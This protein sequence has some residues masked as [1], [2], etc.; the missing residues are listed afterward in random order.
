MASEI[1]AE[2]WTP[3]VIRELL[4]GGHTFNDILRGVPLMSRSLLSKRLRELE[5]AGLIEK[6]RPG[7]RGTPEYHLTQAGRELEPVMLQLTEWGLRWARSEMQKDQLDPRPLM[8]DIHR[9]INNDRLPPHRVVVNFVFSDAPRAA[10]RRTWLVL[11]GPDVDVCFKDPGYPVD[12]VV[13][14]TVRTL[15]AVWLGDLPWDRAVRAE[16]MTIDGRRE[17]K[18]AFPTWLALSGVAGAQFR[19]P[20]TVS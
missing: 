19:D 14:G 5:R 20:A 13:T 8:W 7:P 9:N 1:L 15:V 10:L 16:G 4:F 18:R 6:C 11:D 2:R 12:L 17:L 3:L